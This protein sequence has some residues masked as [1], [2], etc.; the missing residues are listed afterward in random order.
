MLTKDYM[1]G[2]TNLQSHSYTFIAD[3]EKLEELEAKKDDPLRRTKRPFGGVI[4]DI[5]RRYPKYLSDLKDALSPQ[6][7]ATIIFIYF[8]AVSPAITFGGLLGWYTSRTRTNRLSK[9]IEQNTKLN[10]DIILHL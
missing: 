5:K 3:K 9:Y 8:A 6:V 4:K 7:I 1:K 2:C 10:S